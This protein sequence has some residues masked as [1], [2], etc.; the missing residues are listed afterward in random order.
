M[1]IELIEH[2]IK[3]HEKR[4]N[5]HS[6]KIDKLEQN[7]AATSVIVNNICEKLESQTKAL[8]RLIGILATGIVGFFFYVLETLVTK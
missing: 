4:I 1:S 2:Q 6:E 5:T 3:V 7:E 8:N